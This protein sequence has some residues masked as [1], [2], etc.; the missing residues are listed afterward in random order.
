MEEEKLFTYHYKY[1][2]STQ[3]SVCLHCKKEF[4]GKNI[5]N[6]KRHVTSSHQGYV[7]ETNLG[8]NKRKKRSGEVTSS[9]Q[10]PPIKKA[11]KLDFEELV[12]S[13][14]VLVTIHLVP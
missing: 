10:E 7:N 14:I 2:E 4:V 8:Y 3:K 11:R 5:S 6:L 12:R 1:V 13:C 9:S